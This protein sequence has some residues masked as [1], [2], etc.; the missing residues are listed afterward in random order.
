MTSPKNY[1]IGADLPPL[2]RQQTLESW[3]RYAAVNDE[4]APL[5]MSD[6]AGIAAGFPSAIGMGNL[7]WAYFHTLLRNW[8]SGEGEIASIACRFRAPLLHGRTVTVSGQV[9][10]IAHAGTRISV[11]LDAYDD[12]GVRLSDARAVVLLKPQHSHGVADA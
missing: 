2:V 3:N 11:D 1:R 9:A 4:F 7:L 8:L 12:T 10:A 5:H 6:S